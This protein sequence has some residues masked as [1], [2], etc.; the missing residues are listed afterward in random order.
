MRSHSYMPTIS[1]I[2]TSNQAIYWFD[3]PT[4]R[5]TVFP[6]YK[7]YVADFGIDRAYKSAAESET[8]PRISLFT[9]CCTA[10]EVVEQERRGFSSHIFSFGCVFVEMMATILSSS[11]YDEWKRLR[12]LF[13]NCVGSSESPAFPYYMNIEEIC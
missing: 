3:P 10:P 1:G 6:T 4:W 13:R 11:V 9:P 12:M 8:D 7:I 2:W 5:T